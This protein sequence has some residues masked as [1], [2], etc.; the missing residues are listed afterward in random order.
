[1]AFEHFSEKELCVPLKDLF[2]VGWMIGGV[3]CSV[4]LGR[5]V[6]LYSLKVLK[7]GRGVGVILWPSSEELWCG[8][9]EDRALPSTSLPPRHYQKIDPCGGQVQALIL[10]KRI[11]CGAGKWGSG[12]K[13]FT[14]SRPL[15]LA[16][17]SWSCQVGQNCGK[18]W[19]ESKHFFQDS[20]KEGYNLK[21]EPFSYVLD[22]F[23]DRMVL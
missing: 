13:S 15:P 21:P 18:T 5:Y 7:W 12:T 9:P 16:P 10:P 1:M 23:Y 6:G 17:F 4:V 20:S 19:K 2:L 3:F 8:S 22:E 14:W 11:K